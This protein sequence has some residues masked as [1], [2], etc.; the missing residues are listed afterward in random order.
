LLPPLTAQKVETSPKIMGESKEKPVGVY[1][2]YLLHLP[3]A[4]LKGASSSK[5]TF[6]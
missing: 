2:R 5:A 3:K 6:F 4:S 1:H